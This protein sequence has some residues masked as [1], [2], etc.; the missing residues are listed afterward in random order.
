[1]TAPSVLPAPA[2]R[3]PAFAGAGICREAGFTLPEDA[4]RPMFDDDSW[5]FTG[6][7]ALPVQMRLSARRLDFTVIADTGWRTLAKELIFA[8]LCP[9]HPAVAPLPRAYRMP[10]H[11]S[12]AK[13]RLD[14]LATWFG[15][16]AGKG[17]ASLAEVDDDCC[18]E[19]LAHRRY[20]LDGTGTVVGE[21]SPAIR[22]RAAQ[23]A[24]E[25]V[26]YRELFSADRVSPGLRPWSGLRP[27]QVGQQQGQ[28]PNA[29]HSPN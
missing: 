14:E 7:A 3:P 2:A 27:L 9:R 11:L 23:V 28:R 26:S 1:M 18:R 12:T 24:V 22:R 6:V 10:L 8:L 25:L 29:G 16:L 5:D 20:V 19:Y 13:G 21:R 15:W 4:A 17:I